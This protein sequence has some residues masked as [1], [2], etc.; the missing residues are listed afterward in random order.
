MSEQDFVVVSSF[1]F[2]NDS[3]YTHIVNWA[4]L[5]NMVLISVEMVSVPLES[6]YKAS[7]GSLLFQTGHTFKSLNRSSVPFTKH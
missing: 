6:Q 4:L 3:P 1:R 7:R 5:N 2:H